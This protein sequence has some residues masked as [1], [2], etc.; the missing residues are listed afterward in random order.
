VPRA[1]T[2]GPRP[3]GGRQV[4]PECMRFQQYLNGLPVVGAELLHAD[5]RTGEA[6][7]Q[8]PLRAR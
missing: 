6:G 2:A 4:R 8:Q 5:R 1:R 3:H 7:V